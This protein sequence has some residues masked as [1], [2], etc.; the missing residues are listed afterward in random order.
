M[1]G[2]V[3]SRDFSWGGRLG[4]VAFQIPKSGGVGYP[5]PPQITSNRQISA[6]RAEIWGGRLGGVA[7]QIPKCGGTRVPPTPP[8]GGVIWK[9][10]NEPPHFG[11]EI[12]PGQGETKVA[13]LKG[14]QLNYQRFSPNRTPFHHFFTC[15]FSTKLDK[16][17]ET[18]T[19]NKST[20]GSLLSPN[21]TLF[22]LFCKQNI[23]FQPNWTNLEKPHR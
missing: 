2:S 9:K 20:P 6:L 13:F 21:R 16:F 3:F 5:L 19:R 18:P 23:F 10:I 1:T 22:H 7:F 15:F 8:G 14:K 17:G 12:T 11:P 4:G